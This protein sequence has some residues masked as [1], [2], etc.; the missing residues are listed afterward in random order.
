MPEEILLRDYQLEHF[1]RICHILQTHYAYIDTSNM[2]CGK[3]VVTIKLAKHYDLSLIVVCP[4]SVTTN[5][6]KECEKYGVPLLKTITYQA[7]RGTVN[8]PPTHGLLEKRDDE[9]VESDKY[10]EMVKKG[11]LLV[12]DEV[13]KVKN[14]TVERKCVHT[15]VKTLVSMNNCISRVAALSATPC[16]KAIHAESILKIAGIIKYSKLYDYDYSSRQYTRLGIQEVIDYC[17]QL[18]PIKTEQILKPVIIDS[19]SAP[20]LCYDLYTSIIKD[21]ISSS[22]PEP[23]KVNQII[24]DAKNG[25]YNM[26]T[27]ELQLIADGIALL[28]RATRF[29]DDTGQITSH[30]I[31]WGDVTNGEMMTHTG[32]IMKAVRLATVILDSVPNSKVVICG[33]YPK[34]IS[35][36]LQPL[37]KYNPLFMYGQTKVKDR[38]IIIDKFQTPSNAHRVLITNPRVGGIGINLDDR[39]D[40]GDFPRYML[41]LPSFRFTDSHQATGRIFRATT[42]SNAFIRF[43]YSK[44]YRLEAKILDCL[45][46][47]AKVTRSMLYN[48]DDVVFPGEYQNIEEEQDSIQSDLVNGCMPD[49]STHIYQYQPEPVADI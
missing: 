23:P 37:S 42:R 26:T 48:G 17:K 46:R 21:R 33:D 10:K 47:K 9:Y 39:S 28:K 18:D 38:D 25:F 13:Q 12:L 22:M 20:L 8:S 24:K 32:K 41:I 31:S 2:G 14:D 4:L 19:K 1:N 45:A 43:I 49:T 27:Q 11:I 30:S 3:T 15:L 7:L 35:L 36:A 29:N 6:Q 5:W 16:D 40:G 34:I 44:Q